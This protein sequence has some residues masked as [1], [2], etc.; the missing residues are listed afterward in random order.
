MQIIYSILLGIVQGLTEF[1]PVSS[2]GHLLLAHDLLHF[3]FIDAVSFDVALH[4]GTLAA[5][6][7]FFWRDLV[8]YILAFFNSFAKWD[9]RNNYNQRLAWFIV[10]GSIPAGLFGFVFESTIDQNLRNPWLVALLLIAVGVLFLIAERAFA[11]I[12]ELPQMGWGGAIIVGLAQVLALAPGVSRSGITMV[13]G[14]SQGLKREAAA[15]FSFL[16]SIPVV[17]G[18]GAKKM[19]EAAQAHLPGSDWFILL[20]GAVSAAVVG[21]LVIRFLLRYLSSHSLNVF[22]YYRFILGAAIVIYLLAR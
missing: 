17:F 16:L 11:R 21:Y 22:A 4:L 1:L 18:A 5:L 3:N 19:L 9:L 12:K 14:M 13:A 20:A 10:V 2:S 15:R 7:L 8:T 6:V